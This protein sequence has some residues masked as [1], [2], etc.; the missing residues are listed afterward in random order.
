MRNRAGTGRRDAEGN[1]A[2]VAD[3]RSDFRRLRANELVWSS[4]YVL[5]ARLGL[6]LWDGPGGFQART[7]TKPVYR[8]RGASIPETASNRLRQEQ[9]H[10][11]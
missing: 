7:F 4:D 9:Q 5:D 11:P 1:T 6:R 8:K 2:P 3:K 10:H